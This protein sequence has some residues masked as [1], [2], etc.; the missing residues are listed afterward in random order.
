[1]VS[2]KYKNRTLAPGK[3]GVGDLKHLHKK[4][5]IPNSLVGNIQDNAAPP[6]QHAHINIHMHTH[7]LSDKKQMSR[8]KSGLEGCVQ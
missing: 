3:G 6:L 1:M 2:I 8:L 5:S 4:Q 7:T